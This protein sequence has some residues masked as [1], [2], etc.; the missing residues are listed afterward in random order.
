MGSLPKTALGIDV[1]GTK[2]AA[3]IVTFPG[4]RIHARRQIPTHPERGSQA[5]L[6]D[7]VRLTA[8]LKAET[9][10]GSA[11]CTAIGIGLC[12]LVSPDGQI[13]SGNCVRWKTET[14]ASLLEPFGTVTVE[15]DVRAAARAEALV[16]AGR[17]FRSFLYVTVGT[18]ISC[19]LM[20][21]GKPYLGARGATGTLASSPLRV[22]CAH[23]GTLNLQTLEDLASGPGLVHRLNRLKP[24]SVRTGQDVFTAI[25]R[26]DADARQVVQTACEALGS[27]VGLMVNVLDPEAVILGGGL[28]QSGEFP[29]DA[30]LESTRR[31]IWSGIHRD[32]PILRAE[33]GINAGVIG[34]AL[35]ALVRRPR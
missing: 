24:G 26:G 27:T 31:N 34:A 32:L 19:C 10:P 20:E 6:G 9:V 14:V 25:A 17:R 7:V 23:C 3:A 21:D 8:E 1:G 11:P 29:W 16:G 35:S 15:A 12:E 28:A 4:G 13:L 22:P 30:F 5:V 18:G 2:I 33:T